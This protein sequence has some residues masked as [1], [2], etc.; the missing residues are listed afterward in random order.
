MKNIK[1]WNKYKYSCNCI[2]N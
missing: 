2:K 1:N